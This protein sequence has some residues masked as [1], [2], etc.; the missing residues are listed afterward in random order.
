MS[1][2]PRPWPEVP[3]DTACCRSFRVSVAAS[4]LVSVGET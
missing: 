1:M 2:Q 4:S 3:A